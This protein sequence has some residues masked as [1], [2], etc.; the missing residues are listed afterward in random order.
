M[1]NNKKEIVEELD[2]VGPGVLLSESRKNQGL[3]IKH[4]ASKLNFRASIVL[5]IEADI[6][7]KTLPDTYNRGYLKNYA[8]LLGLPAE[9]IINSYEKLNLLQEDSAKMRSFSRGTVKK[10]ENN[11]LMWIS[12]LILAIF[13]GFTMMWWL[14][15][16]KV[17]KAVLVPEPVKPADEFDVIENIS[18]S[19]VIENITEKGVV[20]ESIKTGITSIEEPVKQ[21]AEIKNSVNKKDNTNINTESNVVEQPFDEAIFIFSG[22]CWVNIYDATGKRIAWGIKKSGYIMPIQGKSP[23]NITIGKPELV[24]IKF[25]GADV[26][27]SSFR[28][29][30]ISKF[31]LPLTLNSTKKR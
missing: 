4:V 26:D 23:F 31:T 1:K 17:S 30:H 16:G 2:V 6:Y 10:A 22:D 21:N 29:G 8:K 7:D 12:Y 28:E 24:Q 18:P 5:N 9:E 15:E 20:E 11:M 25:N 19:V 3:S 14:Q 13:I 27:I